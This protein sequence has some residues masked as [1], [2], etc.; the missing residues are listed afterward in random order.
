MEYVV[1]TCRSLSHTS[2]TENNIVIFKIVM[3]LSN[4]YLLVFPRDLS[5]DLCY[6]IYMNDLPNCVKDKKV[7]MH[8]DDTSVGNTSRRINDIKTNLMPDLLSVCDWLK[9][10]HYCKIR[11]TG[12]I[13]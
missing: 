1:K 5:W 9:V 6:L 7:T 10:A 2:E 8:A 11:Q 3:I 4:P 12:Q 13:S